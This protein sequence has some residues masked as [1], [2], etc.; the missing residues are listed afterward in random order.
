MDRNFQ[1]CLTY[2]IIM[3]NSSI[4]LINSEDTDYEYRKPFKSETIHLND[5]DS[6]LCLAL[7]QTTI[8]LL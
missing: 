6:R 2:I 3:T 4:Q 1:T 8:N 5:H 7:A